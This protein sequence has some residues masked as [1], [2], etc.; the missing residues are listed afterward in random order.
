MCTRDAST[1][2]E[3]GTHC[4]SSGTLAAYLESGGREHP[5]LAE[6]C[7]ESAAAAPLTYA[8]FA[9]QTGE[10]EQRATAAAQLA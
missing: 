2:A 6:R 10:P 5:R 4:L 8:L 9:L 7:E 3:P 1:M